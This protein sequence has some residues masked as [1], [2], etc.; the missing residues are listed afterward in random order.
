MTKRQSRREDESLGRRAM[1]GG[2]GH[3]THAVCQ[4]GRAVLLGRVITAAIALACVL[5]AMTVAPKAQAQALEGTVSIVPIAS[6][7]G[8]NEGPFT[9]SVV[10]ENLQHNGAVLYDDNRDGVA[11]R[12]VQS[13]GLGAFEFSIEYDQTIVTLAGVEEGPGLGG[14]GRTF[15]CLGP[16]EEAGRL[17]FACLSPQPEPPGPQGSLTLANVSFYPLSAGS[18]PLLLE[19]GLA[20]PLGDDVPVTV[21]GGVVQVTGS[22][23]TP[24]PRPQPNSGAGSTPLA[25]LTAAEARVTASAEPRQTGPRSMTPGDGEQVRERPLRD[26][27]LEAETDR[28]IAGDAGMRGG[29]GRWLAAALGSLAALAALVLAATLW[30]RHQRS[31]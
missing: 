12:E 28:T 29:T 15:Q 3:G 2:Y 11:D 4:C 22:P 9:V 20:G 19:A 8:L 14:T 10:V 27:D 7:V 23:G 17:R 1:G 26:G 30:R 5:A 18:S 25:S 31:G 16:A 6:T 13:A 24:G 21:M